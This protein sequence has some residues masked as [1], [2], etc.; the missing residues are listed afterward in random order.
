MFSKYNK[1]VFCKNKK[2]VK[3]NIQKIKVNFYI[4][5]IIEDL[6]ISRKKLNEIKTYKCTRCGNLQ[7]KVWFSHEII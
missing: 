6:E 3:S 7:N 4:K 1:C 2:L 5:A